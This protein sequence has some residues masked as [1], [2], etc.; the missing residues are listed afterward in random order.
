MLFLY[1]KLYFVIPDCFARNATVLGAVPILPSLE[2]SCCNML[3]AAFLDNFVFAMLFLYM[4]F[5][6]NI[7][8]I[9][10]IG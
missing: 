5:I 10:L 6:I 8:L 9:S 3:L 2:N 7:N 1:L 4:G